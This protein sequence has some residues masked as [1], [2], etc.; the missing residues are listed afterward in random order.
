VTNPTYTVDG[1][2]IQSGIAALQDHVANMIRAG[3]T[4]YRI[5]GELAA[6]YIADSSSIFQSRVDNWIENY[7]NVMTKFQGLADSTTQVNQ[8]MDQGEDEAGVHGASWH[9]SDEIYQALA[10][11]GA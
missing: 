10:P 3:Q 6:A 7:N 9:G 11:V 8:I 1:G 4:A 2:S 5:K